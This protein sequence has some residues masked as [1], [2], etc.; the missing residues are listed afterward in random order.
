M[1]NEEKKLTIRIPQQVEDALER[2]KDKTA[3]THNSII[4]IAIL[5]LDKQMK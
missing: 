4:K 5:M 1:K 2:L 3:C